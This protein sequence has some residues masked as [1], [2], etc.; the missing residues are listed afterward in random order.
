MTSKIKKYDMLGHSP[1]ELLGRRHSGAKVCVSGHVAR[2][3]TIVRIP[4][5]VARGPW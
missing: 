5:V 3:R 2:G 1:E 4:R